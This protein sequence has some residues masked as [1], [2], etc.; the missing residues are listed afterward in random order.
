MDSA[1][2]TLG[3]FVADL[4]RQRNHNN[5]SLADVAGVSES[6]IR[7]LLKHGIDPR[8]KDPDARTLRRVADALAID[9]LML[10]RLA[11]YIPPPPDANSVRA[12]YLADVFDRLPPEKQ[13]AVMGV[14]EAMSDQ[15][16][17]KA[18]IQEMRTRSHDAL[19]GMDIAFPAMIRQGAN[20]LMAHYA[21]TDPADVSRI[22]PEVEVLRSKWA[23][24][25]QEARMRITALIR[26]KLSLDYDPTMVDSEWRD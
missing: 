10:F 12:E 8:A 23:N 20:Q 7:N 4:M 15:S 26:R 22:E 21:M 2:T 1:A 6:V 17:V 14:L 24:L 11:G 3:R 25:P 13:D 5:S 16:P 9:G 18:T 19:A